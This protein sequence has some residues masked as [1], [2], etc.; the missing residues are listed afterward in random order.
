MR[1]SDKSFRKQIIHEKHYL[2]IQS[3]NYYFNSKERELSL[4]DLSDKT[5]KTSKLRK[6][7]KPLLIF[8]NKL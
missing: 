4:M 5:T 7:Q 3:I 6:I 1:K 2:L 8:E